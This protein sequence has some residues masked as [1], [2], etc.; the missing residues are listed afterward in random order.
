V[1]GGFAKPRL[2]EGEEPRK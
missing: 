2:E 1:K